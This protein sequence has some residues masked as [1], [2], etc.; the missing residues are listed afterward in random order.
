MKYFPLLLL[1]LYLVSVQVQ[2][3]AKCIRYCKKC[4]KTKCFKH[5]R[6]VKGKCI[7]P[8]APCKTPKK[9][10]ENKKKIIRTTKW[11]TD[12]LDCSQADEFTFNVEWK[13]ETEVVSSLGLSFGDVVGIDSSVT[14]RETNTKGNGRSYTCI[15]RRSN[16]KKGYRFNCMVVNYKETVVKGYVIYKRRVGRNRQC[17]TTRSLVTVTSYS[18]AHPACHPKKKLVCPSTGFLNYNGK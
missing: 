17:K 3:E 4:G 14:L 2:V 5:W 16:V 7:A 6:C 1:A 10:W 9:Y 13:R 15:R 8:P 11:K 18:D 12:C